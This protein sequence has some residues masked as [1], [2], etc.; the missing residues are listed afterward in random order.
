MTYPE[1]VRYLYSLGNEVGTAK[2]GLDRIQVLLDAL[3]NPHRAPGFIHVAGTN[4]KGSTSAMIEAGLRHAGQR[5]GLYTSPH[6]VEPVERIQIAGS[7]STPQQFAS[8]FD[9]VHETARMLLAAG[10]ID[11]HPTYFETVTAM[12]FL[13][14]RDLNVPRV[15]LETGLGGRLDA[16]NVVAPELCVITPIDFDHQQFLGNTLASIAA[17]KAG[18]LKANVPAVIAPQDPEAGRVLRGRGVPIVDASDWPIENLS[19][20][21]RGS[22][23]EAGGI[24]II[25]PLAGEHQVD[26]G[27]TAAVALAQLGCSADG[28]AY[29]RWPAR[30]ECVHTFPEIIL[31]GAHN[32]AGVRSLARYIEQFYAGRE[33]WIV[34]GAMRDKDVGAL[35]AILFPLASRLILTAAR[36]TRALPAQQ[37]PAR[38]AIRTETV[39]QAVKL[40]LA[41]PQHAAVFIAG[42]LFVAGEARALLMPEA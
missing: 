10:K 37:I 13:L 39:E 14:F 16:T 6:L 17:E 8:A 34:F 23:F 31:D 18:I 22:R 27:R 41:A 4:G 26:N 29:T 7:S 40:A 12:A 1:A 28:I 9:Q 30:L 19:L 20:D 15:V 3:G 32:L 5:T 42:S 24:T 11:L 33:V 35:G 21:A 2:L 38:N 25:C 36:N